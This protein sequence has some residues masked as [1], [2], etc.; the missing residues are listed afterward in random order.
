[1]LTYLLLF[2][3]GICF[4]SFYNVLGLRLLDEKSIIKPRSHCPKCMHVLKWYEL[5]PI[6]S[7][8]FLKGKCHKCKKKISI[9]YPLIEMFT[10][11]LFC[12]NYYVF[13][14]SLDFL[15]GIVISSILV[16]IYLTDFKEYIILDEVL[17][18]GGISL[19]TIKLIQYSLNSVFYYSLS[20]LGLFLVF[21]L[22]KLFG[23]RAFK[24][25][26]LGGGDVKLAII[27]GF[28]LGF[29]MGLFNILI[30]SVL[31]FPVALVVTLHKKI[32]EIPFGPFLVTGL[33]VMFIKFDLFK[34][35]MNTI[36][37]W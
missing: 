22:I 17:F 34:E 16:L 9:I 36:F 30:A 14:F 24:R 8:I 10:G 35:L 19:F 11:L 21:Y 37:V 12:I 29:E 33:F 15:T 13:G 5:I 7:Y 27:I 32:R 31:A 28:V 25:E 2:I 3:S 20:A 23:D 4:G 18:F 6:F 26:S 1:M